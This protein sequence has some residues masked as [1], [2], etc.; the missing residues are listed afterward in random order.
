MSVL[1]ATVYF[2]CQPLVNPGHSDA[3]PLSVRVPDVKNYKWRLNPLWYRILHYSC[4]HMA[5]VGVKGL[6][7]CCC[8]LLTI[9]V[10]SCYGDILQYVDAARLFQL[11]LLLLVQWKMLVCDRLC[12]REVLEHKRRPVSHRQSSRQSNDAGTCKLDIKISLYLSYIMIWDF[13][14]QHRLYFVDRCITQLRQIE[15]VQWCLVVT[16]ST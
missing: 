6:I 12:V 9:V 3:Q 14:K 16:F 4:T 13:C 7:C 15:V 10:R 11:L 1:P 8:F 2:C 5:T